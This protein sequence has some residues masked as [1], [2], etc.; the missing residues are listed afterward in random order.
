MGS[1]QWAFRG[2]EREGAESQGPRWGPRRPG[3]C[4]RGRSCSPSALR[5]RPAPLLHPQAISWQPDH[6]LIVRKH[7]AAEAH[8]PER[9]VPA[10]VGRQPQLGLVLHPIRE[11]HGGADVS[12]GGRWQA[13]KLGRGSAGGTPLTACRRPPDVHSLMDLQALAP[14]PVEPCNDIPGHEKRRAGCCHP[15]MRRACAAS[16]ERW[17]CRIAVP[18]APV[19]ALQHHIDCITAGME[20]Q[21]LHAGSRVPAAVKQVVPVPAIFR[22]LHAPLHC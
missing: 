18:S 14:K 8:D 21:T 2:V 22:G 17:S 11:R 10:C 19:F 20:F 4:A 1:T 6:S 13:P 15:S 12:V 16:F 9:A 5:P 7:L 3:H